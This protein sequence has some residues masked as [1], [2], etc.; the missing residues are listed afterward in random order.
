[1]ARLP[2]PGQDDGTWGDILNDFLLQ[3]HES[4]GALKNAG[5]IAQK[6]TKP[7]SGIPKSDLT[8]G[9]QASLDNA[10]A[11]MAGTAPDATSSS[12]G[13]VRLTNQLGGTAIQLLRMVFSQ[14]SI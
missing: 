12:K 14:I 9:F 3:S 10:D 7:P 4:D 8:A 11:A 1:M 6:Y 5:I 13:V 2:I